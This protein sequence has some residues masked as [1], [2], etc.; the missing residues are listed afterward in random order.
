[1]HVNRVIKRRT[2]IENL[3]IR[4]IENAPN[5]MTYANRPMIFTVLPTNVKER[6]YKIVLSKIYLICCDICSPSESDF[7]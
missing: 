6:S 4:K 2:Y 1:M 5:F 7:K 3:K